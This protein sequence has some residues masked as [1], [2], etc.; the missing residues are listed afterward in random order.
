MIQFRIKSV[1]ELCKEF[2]MNWN[3]KPPV[4]NNEMNVYHNYT[5]PHSSKSYKVLI[6]YFITEFD[7]DLSKCAISVYH[8]LSSYTYHIRLDW[9]KMEII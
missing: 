1:E 6:R 4:W 3:S 2:G 8:P 7:P 9:I 5:I